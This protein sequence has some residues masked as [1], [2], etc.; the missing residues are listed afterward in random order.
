LLASRRAHLHKND[1]L[2]L[3]K[4]DRIVSE[5]GWLGPDIIGYQGNTTIFLVIQHSDHSA[6]VRYLP[7]LRNAV[8]EGN[9]SASDLA[10]LEDRV[11]VA[12]GKKQ[13]YG[14]Q[15]K[16]DTISGSYIVPPIENPEKINLRRKQVGL[17]SIENY[18]K[19]WNIIWKPN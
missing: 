15:V 5:Y 18:L 6:Q 4:I 7:I 14:T 17:G 8:S 16:R 10:Y 13:I 11:L 12:Q 3:L 2:N 9:A 1:S 19:R